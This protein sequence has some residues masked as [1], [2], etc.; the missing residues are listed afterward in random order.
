MASFAVQTITSLLTKFSSYRLDKRLALLL[1]DAEDSLKDDPVVVRLRAKFFDA[2][3][4][5][6]HWIWDDT[7][8]EPRRFCVALPS[9][10]GAQRH[11][12]NLQGV[13]T[14]QI[15]VRLARVSRR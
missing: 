13:A 15:I 5:T 8:V 11:W 3:A 12:V 6:K 2:F 10:L 9:T 14:W 4:A 7:S 1:D